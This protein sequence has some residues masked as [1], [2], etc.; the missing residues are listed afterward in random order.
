MSGLNEFEVIELAWKI[1]EKDKE[2]L[3]NLD[4]ATAFRHGN[5]IVVLNIDT[6]DEET[7]WLPG[8]TYFDIGWKSIVMSISDIVVKGA[9]PKGCIISLGVP[10]NAYQE[11]IIELYNGIKSACESLKVAF[12]GGDTSFTKTLHLSVVSVGIADKIISRKTAQPGDIVYSTGL[13]GLTS[14]GYKI[15]LDNEIYNIGLKEILESLYRPKLIDL[16]FW[17]IISKYVNASIDSSD[18]LAMSLNLI[19]EASNVKII[20]EQLPLHPLVYQN[21][22]DDEKA[23]ELALYRGGEEFHFIFTASPSNS[24]KIEDIAREHRCSLYR[25]GYVEKGSG[26]WL[27]KENKIS[28]IHPYGWTHGIKWEK[29]NEGSYS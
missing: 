23:E 21:V 17:S 8:M 22:K 19:S 25:I 12:W 15:L 16:E 29:K 4:D 24:Y 26:V 5:N 11:N 13:F 6:F 18:G 28:L 3:L 27:K 14:L 20:V 9:N 10:D 1:F 7:D 2:E